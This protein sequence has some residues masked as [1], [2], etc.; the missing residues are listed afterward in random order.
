M[1]RKRRSNERVHEQDEPASASEPTPATL[2]FATMKAVAAAG[3]KVRLSRYERD[4][5]KKFRVWGLIGDTRAVAVR[6]RMS[7]SEIVAA[8]KL[9]GLGKAA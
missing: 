4:Q 7:A 6:P 3:P 1:S 5:V 8:R 2:T 9:L